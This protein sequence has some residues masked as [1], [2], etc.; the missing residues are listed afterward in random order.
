MVAAPVA[1]FVVF[2]I[3]RGVQRVAVLMSCGERRARL[4]GR[5]F[6]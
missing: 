2:V 5:R 1:A 3:T 6:A 4:D